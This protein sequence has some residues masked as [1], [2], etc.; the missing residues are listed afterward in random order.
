MCPCAY[1]VD[2]NIKGEK[3]GMELI[4]EYRPYSEFACMPT[5]FLHAALHIPWRWISPVQERFLYQISL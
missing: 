4:A 1:G 3:L 2:I 5:P